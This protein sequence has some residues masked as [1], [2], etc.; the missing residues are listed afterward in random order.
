[1]DT[2]GELEH[3]NQTSQQIE[4]CSLNQNEIMLIMWLRSLSPQMQTALSDSLDGR[5]SPTSPAFWQ[6]RREVKEFLELAVTE[7]LDYPLLKSG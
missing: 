1:M 5:L 4:A 3:R 6:I 2:K 7:R